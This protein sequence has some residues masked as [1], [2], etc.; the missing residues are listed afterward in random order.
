MCLFY[1]CY[2]KALK[3]LPECASLWHDLGFNLFHQSQQCT[4][5]TMATT[6]EKAVNAL[7]KSLSLDSSNYLHWNALGIVSSSKG[8]CSINI[9]IRI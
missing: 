7:K 1:R 4:D 9:D 2:G 8:W 3:I 5:G 6:A